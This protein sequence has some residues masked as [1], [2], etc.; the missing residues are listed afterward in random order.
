MNLT[1]HL[2]LFTWA[3][4][5]KTL[6]LIYGLGFLLLVVPAFPVEE[7]G[8]FAIV[9][10]VFTYVALLN[11]FLVLNPMLR[12]AADTNQFNC[13]IRSGFQ[14]SIV[15]YIAGGLLIWILTPVGAQI[16]RINTSDLLL[17]VPL[18]AA[19]FFRDLG[20]FV[21]QTLYRTAKIFFIETVYFIGS[22]VGFF[23]LVF[24][25]VDFGARELLLAHIIAAS[26]SSLLSIMLGFGG[27]K[28]IGRIDIEAIKKLFNYGLLTLPIGFANI[29]IYG[30]DVLILGAIYTPAV[31]GVYNGAKKVYQVI[32]NIT[33]A[34]GILVLPYASRLSS[35]GRKDELKALFEKTTVYIWIGLFGISIIGWL[36]ADVLYSFLGEAYIGSALLLSI[37][38]FAAP[39]EG[40]FYTAGNILYGIGEA[41][42]VAKVSTYG[43]IILMIILLP[44]V[45]FFDGVGAAGAL[46][47]GLIVLG[48][49]MFRVCGNYVDSGLMASIHRLRKNIGNLLQTGRNA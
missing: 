36:F 14:L 25:L 9:F 5:A 3:M 28:L 23:Y 22:V 30:A 11:K 38:L 46:C 15:F 49:G 27:A 1:R 24:H 32:S 34:V 19:F 8:C 2:G 26:A 35:S 18:L 13:I 47:V 42:R 45:Y 43:M 37:M 31:V 40:I 7:H 17:A 6:P 10:S 48:G 41:K 16:F 21:Q 29:V 12:F 39:F 44:S 4:A 33:Q 20:F